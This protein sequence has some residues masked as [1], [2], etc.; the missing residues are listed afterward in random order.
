MLHGLSVPVVIDHMG[1]LPQPEGVTHPSWR[2]LL[3]L[4]DTGRVW[5][6][7]SGAYLESRSGAPGYEDVGTVARAWVANALER[8]VFGTDWP[9]PSASAAGG[10]LPNDAELLDLVADWVG[11][12][13]SMKQVMVSNPCE[14]YGFPS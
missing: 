7:L 14:L 13:A 9:H 4:V 3:G 6:K 11:S 2:V 8:L 10:P 1:R 12:D 5:V